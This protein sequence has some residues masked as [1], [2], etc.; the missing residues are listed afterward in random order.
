MSSSSNS[1]QPAESRRVLIDVLPG[2]VHS[3][4]S[5][6]LRGVIGLGLTPGYLAAAWLRGA[7]G[8]QLHLRVAARALR[9]LGRRPR[10]L[11]WSTLYQLV[12]WPFDSTRYFEMDFCV[13]AVGDLPYTR[14]L[15]VSSPRLLPALLLDA[16]PTATAVL[17]NPDT[18]DLATTETLL[19]ALDLRGRVELTSELIQ[20][21]ASDDGFD[22]VTSM[23]VLEHIPDDATALDQMWRA[24]RPGGTLVLTLP[25][26]AEPIEQY[27]SRNDYGL[28]GTDEKG[29][30]FWQRLYSQA[31]LEQ[32]IFPR[33]GR[34]VRTVIFGERRSGAFLENAQE[35]RSHYATYPFW[36]ESY[37]VAGEFRTYERIADL[38]GEGVIGLQFTKPR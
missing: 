8:V 37:F 15:D 3:S 6:A 16:R 35:K 29:Y 10:V 2:T 4:S 19:T 13:R 32:R 7:P 28:L 36:R 11:P 25:C 30:V 31:C 22:V 33:V 9:M 18:S 1:A 24:V 20:T 12:F 17:M 26:S 21:Y 34:P 38:P 23:S 27:S 14:L 5:K